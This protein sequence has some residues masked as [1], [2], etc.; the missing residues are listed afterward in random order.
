MDMKKTPTTYSTATKTSNA[1]FIVP[2]KT[3]NGMVSM[4]KT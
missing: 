1:V 4:L 3:E 2:E